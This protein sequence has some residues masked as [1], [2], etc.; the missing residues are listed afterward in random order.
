ML[1]YNLL[2]STSLTVLTVTFFAHTAFA[3]E[4]PRE[5]H[6]MSVTSK[7]DNQLILQQH[8]AIYREFRQ[9][10]VGA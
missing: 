6:G 1:K 3:I 5:L 8:T 9:S 2:T 4:T 10:S 7:T